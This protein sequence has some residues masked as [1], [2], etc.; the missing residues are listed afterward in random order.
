[1]T[2]DSDDETLISFG[3]DGRLLV[4]DL[5]TGKEFMGLE[6]RP[7]GETGFGAILAVHVAAFSQDGA[8]LAHN[9]LYGEGIY[10]WQVPLI[11]RRPRLCLKNSE[12]EQILRSVRLTTKL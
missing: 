3:C 7:L 6:R 1:M 5:A 12:V 4:W 10:L 11:L 2:F 9:R 8:L